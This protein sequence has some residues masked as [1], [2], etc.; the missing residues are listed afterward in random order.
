MS[1][2][3]LVSEYSTPSWRPHYLD[4]QKLW[5]HL[6][7]MESK[8]GNEKLRAD[9]FFLLDVELNKLNSFEVIAEQFFSARIALLEN[10]L[11]DAQKLTEP[12]QHSTD[13]CRSS[14]ETSPR[15]GSFSGRPTTHVIRHSAS[16]GALG[17][18]C[19]ET[20]SLSLSSGAPPSPKLVYEQIQRIRFDTLVCG[21][22]L[23]YL[24]DF[25]NINCQGFEQLLERFESV[26]DESA[27]FYL[28]RVE[29]AIFY[30]NAPYDTLCSKLEIVNRELYQALRTVAPLPERALSQQMRSPPTSPVSKDIE[31][32]N[33]SIPFVD[34]KSSPRQS[35]AAPVVFLSSFVNPS[36]GDIPTEKRKNLEFWRQC[37]RLNGIEFQ[38]PQL[39]LPLDVKSSQS[40]H[41][42]SKYLN[43]SSVYLVLATSA[44][45]IL[46]LGVGWLQF[47]RR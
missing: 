34:V 25:A 45:V 28:E 23:L 10:R 8:L 5:L 14:P 36:A 46:L 7:T 32:T 42:S 43:N 24:Q 18:I 39:Q 6:S 3:S 16:S 27:E 15:R 30:A 38:I 20:A 26:R 11:K 22:G 44:F 12:L 19:E 33:K 37:R 29:S 35:A 4:F 47:T 40:Q 2:S 41:Q 31:S 21:R 9:F 1:F 13:S 17:S